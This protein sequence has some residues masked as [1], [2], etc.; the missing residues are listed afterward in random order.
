MKPIAYL[1][2][3]AA[4][5]GAACASPILTLTLSQSTL[6]ANAGDTVTFMATALNT[7][8]VTENLNG[9]SFSIT[10]PP[11]LDDSDYFN[12]WPFALSAGQSFGP[13]DLF[14]VTVPLGTGAGS[15][16]G[17]F[18]ITGGPSVSDQNVLGST[19]FTVVVT[20]EPGTVALVS[21]GFALAVLRRRV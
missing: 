21:I 18:N 17:T 19:A 11:T 20:P 3:L 6:T 1:L 14:A 13:T 4:L 12:E 15:Y 9:D 8:A 7:A 16:A 10:A 2:F 5:A